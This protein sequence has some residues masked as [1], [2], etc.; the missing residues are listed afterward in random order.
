M[1]KE[2]INNFASLDIRVGEI[3]DVQDFP[4][5]MNPSYILEI[6]FG[7]NIGIKKTSAQITNYKKESLTGRKCIPVINLGDKQIGPIISQCLILG[8]ISK[9]NTVNLISP[10]DKASIG[11]KIA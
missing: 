3:I 8:S 7:E 5:A 2:N 9:D 4:E 11:D 6:N 1:V 10:E